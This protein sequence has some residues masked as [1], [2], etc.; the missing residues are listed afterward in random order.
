MQPPDFFIMINL[1]LLRNYSQTPWSLGVL[2]VKHHRAI[3]QILEKSLPEEKAYA[4]FVSFFERYPDLKNV[5]WLAAVSGGPDS[6]AM[7]HM[8]SKYRKDNNL[9]N[10]IHSVTLDHDLRPESSKEAA[11]VAGWLDEGEFDFSHHILKWEGEK[12]KTRVMEEAREVRYKKIG[13]LASEVGVKH[14]FLAHHLDDQAE[15]FLIRLS[16]GSGLDG[17]SS[18]TDI[19]DGAYLQNEIF[20]RP[21]LG[22]GKAELVSYCHKCNVSFVEDPSNKSSKYLRARIRKYRQAL[23]IEGMSS[24]RL[25]VTASRIRRAREALD[26]YAEIAKK[27]ALLTHDDVCLTLDRNTLLP[28]PEEVQ[29]R[30]LIKCIEDLRVNENYPPR[31][32]KMENLSDKIFTSKS[33]CR[34]TLGGLIFSVRAGGREIRIE[35]E[36]CVK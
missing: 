9:D 22:V 25:S 35:K 18:M 23:E 16:K 17:L 8:L 30:V 3:K 29:L 19:V 26:Y 12:P 14:I 10:L 21:L 1:I 31:L 20:C 5:P 13:D 6:M 36:V 32:E 28:L 4:S 34:Y 24:K 27:D 2:V 15:T 33:F 11:T 7:C